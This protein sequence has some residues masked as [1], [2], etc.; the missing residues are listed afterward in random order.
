MTGWPGAAVWRAAASPVAAHEIA[1]AVLGPAEYLRTRGV[2]QQAARL[3][4]NV[5]LDRPGRALLL[6][7]AWLHDVG[8]PGAGRPDG[9]RALRRAGQEP[10]ARVAAHRRFAAM[11]AAIR[12]LTPLTAEF[13]VPAGRHEG[14]L[15]LLDIAI[16]TTDSA[17]APC[18]PATVLR[19]TVA[20]QGAADAAVRALVAL[21]ARLADDPNARTLLELV[22]PRV[23]A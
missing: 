9:A 2:A 17:G 7:A 1:Q 4:R 13:P 19:A 5:H 23:P 6:A 15:M 22:A 20:R 12:G 10:L 18:S 21:V 8:D 11:E 16:V 3:A 14:L